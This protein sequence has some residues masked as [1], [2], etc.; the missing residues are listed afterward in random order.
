MFDGESLSTSISQSG[1]IVT[2]SSQNQ[3]D[4]PTVGV[5]LDAT[6]FYSE[7]GGQVADCG[8]LSVVPATDAAGLG[9]DGQGQGGGEVRGV[10]EVADVRM[11]GGF[12]LHVGRLVSGR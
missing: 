5:V 8:R 3:E 7:A 1:G 11:F 6:P 10:V 12:A 4:A 2:V 9:G